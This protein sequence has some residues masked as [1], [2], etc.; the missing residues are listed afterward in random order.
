MSNFNPEYVEPFYTIK[1]AAKNFNIHYRTLLRAVK[2]GLVPH[3]RIAN[4]PRLILLSELYG[5]MEHY[6]I[7]TLPPREEDVNVF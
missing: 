3:H 5:A 4:S 2:E 7:P 1:E 6:Y